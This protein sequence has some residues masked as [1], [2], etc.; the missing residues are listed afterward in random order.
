MADLT[1]LLSQMAQGRASDLFV[2]EGRPPAYRVDGAIVQTRHVA[3][4]REEI[5][6]FL[7]SSLPPTALQQLQHT[8][9]LDQGISLANLGR[10]RLNV[11]RQRGLLALVVRRIPKGDLGFEDLGLP[12]SLRSMADQTR[13]L[14][15]V[16]GAT[17]SGKSTT[18]AALVH[19]INAGSARHIITLEDPIEFVH[20]DLRSIVTQREIGIDTLDFR[21]A[22]RHVVRE[23]PDV[24]VIGELR[25]QESVEVALAAALTGHLV[26]ASLHTAD[27]AQTVQRVLGFF[28]ESGRAQASI[29]L[30]TALVGVV[31]Q[32]L[33]PRSDGRGRV[34]AVELL[35]ATPAVRRILREQRL[36]ELP[37]LMLGGEGTWSFNRALVHLYEKQVIALET[38][39]AFASNPEEFKMNAQG[40]E[41]SSVAFA[42]ERADL[43]PLGNL[44]LRTLLHVAIQ[45]GASDIH[46]AV[47]MPPTFRIHG[48]LLP[49]KTPDLGPAD[50]RRLLFGLLSTSQREAFELERE[51]DFAITLTGKYRCR[52]NA[53][54]QRGTVA[55]AMRLIPIEIPLIETLGLPP[56]VIALANRQQGLVLVT[57]PTGSGKSTTL[58]SLVH[59]INSTRNCHIITIEDPIEFVH[60][61]GTATVE[62]R[63]VGADTKSFAAAL[64]FILRQDPDVILVGELRDVETISAALTAAETGHLVFA[65]MHTNDAPQ[66]VDRIIDVFPPFQQT[67]VRT[68]LASCLTAVISQRLLPRADGHGRVAA[69]EILMGN[70]AVRA[71]IREGKSFQLLSVIE[72]GF[73][74]GMCTLERSMGEQVRAGAVTFDEALRCARSHAALKNEVDKMAVDPQ[75]SRSAG[76]KG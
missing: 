35:Q 10:F 7:T 15:L 38:G 62:Q 69:F 5:E 30:S 52:V 33:L 2:A 71:V 4:Q 51:L 9:D 73:R 34:A 66:T 16:V 46:V 25:D 24:I 54:Y 36:E 39:M 32:R 47:G 55:L 12:L 40:L 65:T 22:L 6:A 61:N 49:L 58:A 63:E 28:A 20:E 44:D 11:H 1:A 29:D 31:A 21:T 41:R 72:T 42:T 23:S 67:Q 14:I 75:G 19:H 3:T 57:G 45:N 60:L 59:L 53:H 68:Q 37:D 8:G 27:A 18:M 13:G 26:I 48:E 76:S 74:D 17:G 43:P 70:T 64:K 50:T 56:A